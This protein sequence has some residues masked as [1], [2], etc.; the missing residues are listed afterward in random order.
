MHAALTG[1]PAQPLTIEACRWTANDL[2]MQASQQWLLA[3]GLVTEIEAL[4]WAADGGPTPAPGLAA[5]LETVEA[6]STEVVRRADVVA[7]LCGVELGISLEDPAELAAAQRGVD[8]CGLAFDEL[9]AAT[10]SLATLCLG[11]GAGLAWSDTTARAD[12]AAVATLKFTDGYVPALSEDSPA[13]ASTTTDEFVIELTGLLCRLGLDEGG[14]IELSTAAGTATVV[15]ESALAGDLELRLS[16]TA[17]VEPAILEARGWT[18]VGDAWVAS[19][20]APL[21]MRLPAGLIC[22]TFARDLA[23]QSMAEVAIAYLDPAFD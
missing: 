19:Y 13:I 15:V 9:A 20:E 2:A 10:R 12:R 16:T 11:V 3:K 5:L 8:A 6:T 17:S 1:R 21:P 4:R 23:V 7:T 18:A 22:D 14:A